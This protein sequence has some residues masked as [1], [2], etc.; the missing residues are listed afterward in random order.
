MDLQNVA[1]EGEEQN[2]AKRTMNFQG[3]TEK[4]NDTG[5]ELVELM[6]VGPER[7]EKGE[8]KPSTT[9]Q[10]F[11]SWRMLFFVLLQFSIVT[12]GLPKSTFNMALV[13]S[14]T[15]RL[16]AIDRANS[17]V[18]SELDGQLWGNSSISDGQDILQTSKVMTDLN[19]DAEIKGLV[20]SS[21]MMLA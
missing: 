4:A 17:S 9:C 7:R 18:S 20:L 19:W 6:N 8:V 14:H 11:L 15:R 21:P 10:Q 3:A 1:L 13:C 2:G 12:L 5:G 16:A